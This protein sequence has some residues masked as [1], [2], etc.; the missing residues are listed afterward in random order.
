MYHSEIVWQFKTANFKIELSV[1]PEYMETDWVSDE[2]QEELL[3]KINNGEL[4]YFGAFV[5]VR[6]KGVVIGSDHLGACC[7]ESI[8]DFRKDPYF[9]DMVKIAVKEARKYLAALTIP[10]IRAA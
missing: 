8:E 1:A 7:Y 9:H 3:R 4:L 2:D 5:S 10:R 6:W